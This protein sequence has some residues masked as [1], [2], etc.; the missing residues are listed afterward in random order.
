M[1]IQALRNSIN[2][3]AEAMQAKN[4]F[5]YSIGVRDRFCQAPRGQILIRAQT[6]THSLS[7]P[8]WRKE[9]A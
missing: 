8:Q 6:P 5:F 7:F 2:R 1:S 4:S 3:P 9:P